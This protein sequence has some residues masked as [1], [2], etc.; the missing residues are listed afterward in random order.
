MNSDYTTLGP[1]KTTTKLS[2]TVMGIALTNTFAPIIT[3]VSTIIVS[4]VLKGKYVKR[5]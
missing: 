4:L 2:F 3:L 5:L 1:R